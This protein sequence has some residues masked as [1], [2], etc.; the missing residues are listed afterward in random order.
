MGIHPCEMP[1]SIYEWVLMNYAKQGDK[2]LDTHLG[3]GSIAK[4]HIINLKNGIKHFMTIY[5]HQL[6]YMK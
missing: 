3:S 6:N 5:Q 1:V 4:K 2:I